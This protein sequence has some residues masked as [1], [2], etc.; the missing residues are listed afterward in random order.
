MS[1]VWILN[2][3]LESRK[4][5]VHGVKNL[6]SLMPNFLSESMGS[7]NICSNDFSHEI[8]FVAGLGFPSRNVC[9]FVS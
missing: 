3:V 5:F 4:L 1:H 7:T 6:K 9:Y 2:F 8:L